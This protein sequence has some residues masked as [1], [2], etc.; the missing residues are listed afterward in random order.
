MTVRIVRVSTIITK[1]AIVHSVLMAIVLLMATVRSVL[2]IITIAKVVTV[3][4][5]RVSIMVKGAT[6]RNA[7][8]VTVR[9][10]LLIIAKVVIVRIVRA[11]IM[12]EKVVRK[13]LPVRSVVLVTMIPMRNIARRN[14]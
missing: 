10:V 4:I 5:V 2:H 12:E 14:R 11:L 7:L 9:N 6:V 13:D 8:M 1:V 3:R